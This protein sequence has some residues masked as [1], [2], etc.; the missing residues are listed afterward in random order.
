[1]ARSSA[2]QLTCSSQFTAATSVRNAAMA[3]NGQAPANQSI[4]DAASTV[5]IQSGNV[6]TV[7][8]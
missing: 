4:A 2:F 5:A 3:E 8:E 7:V 1:M 6:K